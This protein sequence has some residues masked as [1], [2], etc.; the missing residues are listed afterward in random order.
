[1]LE[2]LQTCM[3]E[4]LQTCMLGRLL[5]YDCMLG[6]PVKIEDFVRQVDQKVS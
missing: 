5:T 4:R 6:R 2:R 1:M 3:L